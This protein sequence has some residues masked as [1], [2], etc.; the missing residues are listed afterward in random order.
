MQPEHTRVKLSLPQVSLQPLDELNQAVHCPSVHGWLLKV[1]PTQ[2]EPTQ[3]SQVRSLSR[4]QSALHRAPG[5]NAQVVHALGAPELHGTVRLAASVTGQ[6][7]TQ[8]L[9]VRAWS[10]V[11]ELH[12]A[13]HVVTSAHADHVLVAPAKQ[14]TYWVLVP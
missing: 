10:L 4:R 7:P 8:P 9:Q 14:A 3:P 12:P 6:S 5:T 11:P 1:A 13:A 2:A